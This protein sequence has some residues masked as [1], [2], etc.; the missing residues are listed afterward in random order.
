[1][2]L[3]RSNS[4]DSV[5]VSVTHP[6]LPDHHS[7]PSPLA[8]PPP[9]RPGSQG[10]W[11][12]SRPTRTASVPTS[13]PRRRRQAHAAADRSAAAIPPGAKQLS[14]QESKD[15]PSIFPRRQIHRRRQFHITRPTTLF[16]FCGSWS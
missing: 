11:R 7:S 16:L 12:L 8:R 2:I 5:R 15:G 9:T 10:A 13:V 6:G 3:P 14:S 4:A 1:L